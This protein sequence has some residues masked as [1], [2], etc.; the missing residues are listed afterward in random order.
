[1]FNV[2]RNW[3]D[4]FL[5]EEESLILA[6]LILSFGAVILTM[7][8]IL[9]PLLTG[10]VLAYIM[11][12]IIKFMRRYSVPNSIAVAT[13]FVLFLGAFLGLLFFVIPLVWR[14]LRTLFNELPNMVSQTQGMLKDLPANYPNIISDDQI[15][16]WGDM[17]SAEVG[18]I[19]QWILSF[20]ISQ[21]PVLMAVAVY[22]VL[23]PILVLFIL[24]DKDAILAWCLSLLPNE[25]PL[26]NR[27]AA[28]MDVQ[29]ANYVRG[30]VVEIL[31]VSTATYVFFVLFGL[32]YA[33]LL[34]FLVGL[35]VIVPYL[36]IVV[37]TIP[38]V[39]IAYLQFGWT[40]HF[41]YL[42]GWYTLI[43]GLDG[44]VLVPLLF[45]EAVNLHPVAIITAVLVF[46]SWWGLWG[47]FFAI[48]LA[49]LVKVILTAWPHSVAEAEPE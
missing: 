4:R 33:A 23:I 15:N 3:V 16:S 30:K 12:G 43:Q 7:G 27:I 17:L 13:T 46:G 34:A 5:S 8:S 40:E 24:K 36:G 18:D 49:T 39:I 35:S 22:M 47:V 37:V 42:L 6:I 31:I 48:P 29:M 21:L 32:K 2:L 44:F 11:Q 41:F 9:A 45:S 28:E 19:G 38:V 20:S 25:R 10:I 1:M 26:M 14:Q